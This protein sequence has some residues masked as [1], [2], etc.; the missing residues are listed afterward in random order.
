MT[1]V[2]T[3]N[4]KTAK[5]SHG[6]PGPKVKIRTVSA[7]NA[8][9]NYASEWVLFWEF[10][11]DASVIVEVTSPD[12]DVSRHRVTAEVEYFAELEPYEAEV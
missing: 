10:E 6:H 8:A 7:K 12:G 4:C 1:E 3:Y 5:D 9:M 2:G 11:D